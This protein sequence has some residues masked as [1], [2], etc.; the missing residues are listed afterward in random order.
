MEPLKLIKRLS[1]HVDDGGRIVTLTLDLSK[2]GRL[3]AA[4]RVFLKDQV[5]ENLA[6]E[7]RPEK[8]RDVLRK[9]ARR[10][11][12]F[13]PEL[14]PESDG[15]FLV[16]G[17]GI[18]EAV[19]LRRPLRNLIVVG[20]T[21]YLAPL[22]E[23][24][25][26]SPRAYV[27]ELGARDGWIEEVHLSERR[28][29]V[30]LHV[31]EVFEEVARDA[32]RRHAVEASKSLAR[33]AAARVAGLHRAAPADAIYLVR[34]SDTFLRHLPGE[35][36]AITT[37]NG[38][39][40]VDESA[41]AAYAAAVQ[42]DIEDLLRARVSGPRVAR[43]AR[44]TLDAMRS[45]GVERIYLDPDDP[46]PGVF[47]VSCGALFPSLHARCVYCDGDVAPTSITQEIVAFALA[48]PPLELTFV[49][50]AP[51]LAE[52]GGLAALKRAKGARRSRSEEGILRA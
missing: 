8:D 44:E 52:F 46:R 1:R 33:E 13:L 26:R 17:P 27:V 31:P 47:C 25:R 49:S 29:R 10:L 6:S 45:G 4:T 11:Q 9:I 19:E 23:A 15:L 40:D 36:R 5:F 3:P 16:A 24:A 50:P 18:W 42:M 21:P 30:D 39:R 32:R 22:I 48:H 43:G 34:P 7:A 41:E 20:R 28:R 2:S 51:W 35:L 12:A 38:T 37:L 14:R